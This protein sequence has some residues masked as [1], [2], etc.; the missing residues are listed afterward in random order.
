MTYFRVLIISFVIHTVLAIFLSLLPAPERLDLSQ[1]DL[2]VIDLLEQPELA[3]RPRQEARDQQTFVRNAPVPE[4]LLSPEEREARFASEEDRNVIEEQRARENDMT[5]NRSPL[6]ANQAQRQQPQAQQRKTARSNTNRRSNLDL[7]PKSPLDRAKDELQ[8][9]QSQEGPDDIPVA[10]L[11]PRRESASQSAEGSQAF[12][13]ERGVSTFGEVVPPD[14]KFGE[15]TAL[16]TD[17]HLYY[18]FYARMEEMI[19]NRWVNY[20]RAA[21]YSLP[22]DARTE[23]GRDSWT[24]KLEIVLDGNGQFKKAIL[25]ESSGIRSLDSAPVQAFR[26]A[27]QFPNPPAEMVKEDGTIR[28]YYAF[29]VDMVS[30]Y[31]SKP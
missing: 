25:Q 11:N 17:R 15:F 6:A 24:T 19:R 5:A 13:G 26:D 22:A 2:T 9:P 20:V 8:R 31:A 4:K 27:G 29:N 21:I 3:K 28:I 16:N 1:R 18:T 12:P 10:G 30:R 7:T 23:T 14:V